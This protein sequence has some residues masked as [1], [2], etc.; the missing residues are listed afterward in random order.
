MVLIVTN[1]EDIT[2][3]YVITGLRKKSVDYHRFN[4]EDIFD[5]N[6]CSFLC[7]ARTFK[8][9]I[10]PSDEY[11]SV[12]FR[13]IKHPSYDS[14]D[15][16]ARNYVAY[17]TK[18][19][20]DNLWSTLESRWVSHPFSVYRAENKL[21]QLKT[22]SQLGFQV[23]ETVVSTDPEQIRLFYDEMEGDVIAKPLSGA[24]VQVKNEIFH[25]YT[26]RVSPGDIS[27]LE[28]FFPAPT[29]F[30]RR[31]EKQYELR[32]TVVGD[33]VFAATIDSQSDPESLVDWRKGKLS[34]SSATLPE[35]ISNKCREVVRS[36]NLSFG[37]IDLA[38]DLN[39]NY[40]FFEI[41]PVGQFVWIEMQTGLP[42]TNSLINLLSNE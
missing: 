18:A 28:S 17:Q 40:V 3:D 11:R 34:F 38:V 39:G 12:W 6:R 25:L 27:N 14:I 42:I 16:D 36:L 32:V 37:A 35:N 10:D 9:D 26:N 31:I 29:I 7:N 19:L 5:Q 1:K 24:R 23:P 33:E 21:L 30:Q 15:P 41:N 4:T 8:V 20:L 22:A 2:A 13:R